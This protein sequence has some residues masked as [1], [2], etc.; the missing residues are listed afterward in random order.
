[1]LKQAKI[2]A[3]L[4]EPDKHFCIG[5]KVFCEDY[6]LTHPVPHPNDE[7]LWMLYMEDLARKE[8]LHSA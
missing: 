2:Q 6:C 5:F 4:H 8:K 3:A 1:M 7:E